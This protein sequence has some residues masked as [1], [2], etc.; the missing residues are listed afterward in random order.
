[1]N[2]NN[3]EIIVNKRFQKANLYKKAILKKIF[4]K[5]TNPQK[6]FYLCLKFVVLYPSPKFDAS[7]EIKFKYRETIKKYGLLAI[8]YGKRLTPNEITN[9]FPNKKVYDGKKYECKDWYFTKE[10][11]CKYQMNEPIDEDIFE[12]FFDTYN[13]NIMVFVSKYMS[14]IDQEIVNNG[15][16]GMLEFLETLSNKP[17]N[18]IYIDH[19]TKMA[20]NP[21]T[22][23]IISLPKEELFYVVLDNKDNNK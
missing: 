8:L 17:L 10:Q 3:Y 6:M 7:L 14:I 21:L 13:D 1:M 9:V 4:Q 22:N 18:K 12:Y 2:E 16:M 20:Y 19:K 5:D 23:E 11:E 15:G